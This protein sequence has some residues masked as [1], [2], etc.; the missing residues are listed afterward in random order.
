[1][2]ATI[3]QMMAEIDALL[4]QMK[5]DQDEIDRLKAESKIIRAEALSIIADLKK[6]I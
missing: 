6:V 2:G 5:R 4:A 1:M 3:N